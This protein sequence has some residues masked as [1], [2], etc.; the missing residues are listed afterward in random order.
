MEVVLKFRARVGQEV[1]ECSFFYEIVLFI[2]ANVFKLLLSVDKMDH[3]LF[4]DN[5]S[6]LHAELLGLI[7][8]VDVVEYGKLRSNKPSKVSSFDVTKVESKQELVMPDH[9]SD[10]FIM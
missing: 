5:I 7:A 1:N 8:S 3:L 9:V 6:P 2:K 10:P 4:F